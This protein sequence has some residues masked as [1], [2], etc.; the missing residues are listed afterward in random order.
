MGPS[1]RNGG[2]LLQILGLGV[3]LSMLSILGPTMYLVEMQ[4]PPKDS[5]LAQPVPME[6]PVIEL[7]HEER[8]LSTIKSC[9]P[10]E[11]PDKC[12]QFL[13]Q[14]KN[15]TS[16]QRVALIAP[17]GYLSE[18]L[19]THVRPIVEHHNHRSLVLD[20]PIEL[21]QTTHVP[22]YG[23]GKTHGLTKIIR[24]VPQPLVLQVSDS[25]QSVLEPGETHRDLTIDDLRGALRQI[26][27]CHCRLSHIAA[28]TAILSI[29]WMDI[30]E[31]PMEINKRL[32]SFLLPHDVAEELKGTD[33]HIGES[34]LMDDDQEGFFDAQEAWGTQMLTNLQKQTSE[35]INAIL[36][37]VLVQEL[38]NTKDMSKW[39]CLPFWGAG[40][41]DHPLRM[42][43]F[44]NRTAK[45]LSPD[46]SDPLTSCW[47][48]RD[49]CEAA[50][51]GACPGQ[52]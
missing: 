45:A 22:P 26:L 41:S 14:A 2:L 21:F 38:A 18:V 11:H 48:A 32:Y 23:Y 47:V 51:D 37:Q 7:P 33:D 13:P 46:C 17:P 16:Y 52:K 3:A 5:F 1:S 10:S 42:S 25:L 36:D 39:P 24:V 27:R 31:D 50:G 8:F 49:K 12:K 28:H 40:E 43:R 35:D 19:L 15:G 29:N 20:A 44:L 4:K 34:F 6:V 9:V 30:L